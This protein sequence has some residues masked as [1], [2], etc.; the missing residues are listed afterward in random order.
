MSAPT[1][2]PTFLYR[3]FLNDLQPFY[4]SGIY[5]K[6]AVESFCS[7]LASHFHQNTAPERNIDFHVTH[8]A[9]YTEL[10]KRYAHIGVLI[11]YFHACLGIVDIEEKSTSYAEEVSLEISAERFQE[12]A[13]AIFSTQI[14]SHNLGVFYEFTN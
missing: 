6:I 12:I 8:Y 14:K 4:T 1:S 11:H 3:C 7:Y 2:N 13:N 10:N 9:N 5:P